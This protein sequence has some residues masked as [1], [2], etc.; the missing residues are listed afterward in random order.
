VPDAGFFA[1]QVVV[2]RPEG[3]ETYTL[4]DDSDWRWLRERI[5]QWLRRRTLC[6]Y[7]CTPDEIGAAVRSYRTTTPARRELRP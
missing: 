3:P 4:Y 1:V 2:N 7:L 6:G 5:A